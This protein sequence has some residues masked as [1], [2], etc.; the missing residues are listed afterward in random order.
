MKTDNTILE[1]HRNKMKAWN[2]KRAES[3]RNALAK[4]YLLKETFK[5]QKNGNR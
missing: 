5:K 3:E 4:F 2:N 1:L